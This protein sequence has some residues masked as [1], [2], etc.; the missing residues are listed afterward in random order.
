MLK[1]GS[2]GISYLYNLL[3]SKTE[4]SKTEKDDNELVKNAKKLRAMRSTLE[5]QGGVFA[6]ISQIISYDNSS[7]SVFSECKPYSGKKTIKYLKKFTKSLDTFKNVDIDYNVYKSGSIGQVHIGKLSDKK[8]AIKVQYTDLIEKTEDDLKALDLVASFMY[9][10][11]DIK[12]VIKDIREKM[13]EELDYA[14]ELNNHNHIWNLWK[15]STIVCIP[16][17]YPELCSGKILVTEFLEGDDLT[18]FIKNSDQAQ[19]NS[20]AIDIVR[21]T[22]ENLYKHG[23]FYSDLHYGNIIIKEGKLGVIDFG[24]LHYL[25]E[26]VRTNFLNLHKSIVENDDDFI[27]QILTDMGI[28]DDS[29]SDASKK[30]CLTY[31]K[32]QYEPWCS[33][34]FEF[35]AEWWEKV[36]E[37]NTKLL[38][39]WKLPAELVYFNKVPYCLYHIFVEL[40]AT[41]NFKEIFDTIFNDIL[42]Q[43]TTF[44]EELEKMILV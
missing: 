30:Y 38:S 13:R 11:T 18:T 31:F 24:C 4:D 28:L 21:F 2:L 5:S 41:G 40:K 8:I 44:E 35:T 12:Q 6:K 26:A 3:T 7:S 9:V 16:K 23:I 33:E 17:T 36:N 42:Q 1:T 32:Y 27:L 15:D 37:K 22:F 34:T 14:K 25:K 29:V 39:E 20:I 19:K 43:E 10:F